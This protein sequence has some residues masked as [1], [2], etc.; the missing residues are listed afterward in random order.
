MRAIPDPTHK[1]ALA[2]EQ[3][4][5]PRSTQVEQRVAQDIPPRRAYRRHVNRDAPLD[6]LPQVYAIALR[7]HA[8]NHDEAI[9][10]RLGIA[11]EAVTPLLRLAE[12]KLSRLL[13]AGDVPG[14]RADESLTEMRS[15]SLGPEDGSC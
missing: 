7:L 12:A 3:S 14:S 6:R 9:A 1:A 11:P 4:S 13:G 8:E 15:S 10:D 5:G 2:P